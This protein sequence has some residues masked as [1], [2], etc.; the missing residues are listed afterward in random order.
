M[1]SCLDDE[2]EDEDDWN[3]YETKH[4]R[5]N[6]I[7]QG[8]EKLAGIRE[9]RNFFLANAAFCEELLKFRPNDAYLRE[10]S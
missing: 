3:V 9:L 7:E 1:S 6:I 5:V 4:I 10:L 8:E 2:D